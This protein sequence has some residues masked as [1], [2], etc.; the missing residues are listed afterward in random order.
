MTD[1]RAFAQQILNE[2]PLKEEF[3]ESFWD[4]LFKSKTKEQTTGVVGSYII[5][6][7]DP[8]VGHG[9]ILSMI[10]KKIREYTHMNWTQTK[11]VRTERGGH[12]TQF[13]SPKTPQDDHLIIQAHTYLTDQDE[14]H[15]P[16]KNPVRC[17]LRGGRSVKKKD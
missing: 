9:H 16:F 10:A 3:L 8:A 17:E 15:H 12:K 6:V 7:D 1:P 14:P 11:T 4:D 2:T 13:I 5:P